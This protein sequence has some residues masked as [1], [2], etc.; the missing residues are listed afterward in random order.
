MR[1]IGNKKKLDFTYAL[2]WV[3][4]A[5]AG[6]TLCLFLQRYMTGLLD[7]DE[8]SEMVLSSLLAKNGGILSPDWYYSTEL[9][10]L[11]NQIIFSTLLRVLDSWHKVR[12]LS[13]VAL[14]FILLAAA[15]GFCRSYGLRR[16]FPYAAAVLLMPISMA[17][18]H[19]AKVAQM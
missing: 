9:R 17:T 2:G 4:L 8:S 19:N 7:A 18:P 1:E 13:N 12:M 16:W 3:I 6:I 5:L 11:N 10:V 14:Y 15:W